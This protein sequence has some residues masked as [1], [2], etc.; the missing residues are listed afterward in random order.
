MKRYEGSDLSHI[1]EFQN[2]LS[3]LRTTH[4][5]LSS[6]GIALDGFDAMMDVVNESVGAT[7]VRGRIAMHTLVTLVTDL[8]PNYSYNLYTQRYV[9]SPVLFRETNRTGNTPSHP[10]GNMGYGAM[11]KDMYESIDKR[12]RGFVGTE[13]IKAAISVLGKQVRVRGGAKRRANVKTAPIFL[14]LQY[15]SHHSACPSSS[16]SA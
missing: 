7:S 9:R 15:Y 14:T 5:Y 6:S 8:F 2:I 11:C 10:R 3:V 4:E 16:R 1:C 12:T 13:H